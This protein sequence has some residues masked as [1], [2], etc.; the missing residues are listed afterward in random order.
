M[1]SAVAEHQEL[2]PQ[3]N[4]NT[5][6]LEELLKSPERFINREFSWLQFN[7]RVLEETLNTEHPLLERVRFLSISAANL[8]EFFM[9]RVAGLE[10]QVRQNI[11]IRSPDGKTPAEQL[12]SILQEIDH[13]QMEQQAS[14]AVL[15]Q[16]LAKEDILIVRPGAL[17]DADRQWL[18]AEFEQ[19][20]F[21]VLTPLSID[22]AHPFPF[23][24]NLGFSIGLQLVSKNGR[25]PMT[26]LLRLPPA[27]DRFVRLPDDGNTIRYITLED[28]ANI[29]IHRLY[30]G[31]EVQGSGTFRV[32]RDSDIEVE[33]EAEDLVR[34]FE[35]ALKRRR[36][37]KVIRIETDSEMPASLRQFVVQALNIPDNR[38]AVLPGLLALNTL[39]EITKA[40]REDLRFP[41]YNAR[42]PERVRE[43]AGDCFAAIR[44]KDMV[45]HH[46]YESFDVVVQFLLQAAR[47]PDVLAIKQTLYRTSNDSPIVRA[48][49]DAAEAG[50]SVTALVEL[51]AR[52][53]EEANIRWAR[54]LERAGVQVVFGFIELKTHAKM[55]M[56]VRREEGKLR[57]YCH[58]GTGNYHPITAKIYTDL[59]YF[60][61]N[62]VIAH[63]MA[64]IFN[65]ITGYG[66][67]EQSM[68]LAISPYTMR[69][70]ILRHIDEEIQH[71][72]NGAPA[73][74]WMK[75]NSLVDPD[76]IDALYRASH[77]GVEIDLVVR[78][79]CCLRPQVPGL[80]EKI[81]VK[82]IIGRF[83]EHSRIFCFGNGHG[84]PSD[85]ALVYIGSADMMPRNL[86]RRVETMVP[87]TN[88]TVH[89][90]VLSQ[91]MLGNVID[92]Q[93][94]YEILPDGTS[95]RMEVRRG[96]EPF[97]AQQ[98]FMTNPSL[99]GRGE[100]LKSSAPK[101]IA[102]LLEG[103]NNK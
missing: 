91:I 23:I 12:D 16:Y 41:S 99:S 38:V 54:D 44:E 8:D 53:D 96:E 84:L 88:P 1:D 21:P 2:T 4:D 85:K 25:D 49:V 82:S 51:K 7:R 56:V 36:R 98:Y 14:L 50:K 75:M 19:A 71:A 79:I 57:T 33:E 43:H 103:R 29:F 80:S 34:F 74:I 18:A 69:P 73:A 101:L 92:N 83:L 47:D 61:C 24:P 52:F 58:L 90:Q 93:Q 42:F 26:A 60:T 95:R 5:P 37:G 59:S 15:Q 100:A 22:P 97:N 86:D 48:L 55:S 94:S 40:P 32:I 76:I 70:R 35:T 66:E 39:S 102:G 89:E 10:G 62:P 87:L 31:Y 6:P 46:P 20:I 68:Q 45:V 81:R 67:P 11:V 77:A 27:L 17:S 9:V 64:N 28:V 30:P 63:D 13:L 78:G 72:R 3:S 65:F